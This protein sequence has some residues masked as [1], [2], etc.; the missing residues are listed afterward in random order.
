MNRFTSSPKGGRAVLLSERFFDTFNSNARKGMCQKN[1]GSG[2][3]KN[4]V[5]TPEI[6]PGIIK[7]EDAVD[8]R[9]PRLYLD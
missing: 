1:V 2:R 3:V 6:S 9:H 5:P 8:V 7:A 4:R